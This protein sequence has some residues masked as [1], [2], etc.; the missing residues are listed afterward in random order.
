VPLTEA[1]E[2]ELEAFHA[3][4]DD[5]EDQQSEDEG[6]EEN[7][8]IATRLEAIDIRFEALTERPSH[9]NPEGWR[10]PVL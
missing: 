8:D 4:R 9:W 5:L 1:E 2:A 6:N 10:R 3:E 7:P